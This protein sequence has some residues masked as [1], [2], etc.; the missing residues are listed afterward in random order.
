MTTRAV[1]RSPTRAGLSFLKVGGRALTLLGAPLPPAL[2]P[3]PLDLPF[4]FG[5]GAPADAAAEAGGAFFDVLFV[6][7]EVLV[8]RQGA[9]GGCFV[10]VRVDDF[11]A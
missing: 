1:R 2:A 5:R 9:P 4:P 7:E 6:D 3:P 8:I 10:S 11:G